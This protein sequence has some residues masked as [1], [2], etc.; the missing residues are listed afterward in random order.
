MLR[1]LARG[2]KVG[3][4]AWWTRLVEAMRFDSDRIRT[5]AQEG[6]VHSKRRPLATAEA[7]D[8]ATPEALALRQVRCSANARLA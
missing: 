2:E 5:F 3:P 6:A 8:S 1:A 4:E 7:R